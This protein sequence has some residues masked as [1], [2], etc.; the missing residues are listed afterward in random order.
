[1]K[2]LF[3]LIVAICNMQCLCADVVYQQN[4]DHFNNTQVVL[5]QPNFL[6]LGNFSGRAYERT[7]VIFS[8]M[9]VKHGETLIAQAKENLLKGAAERGVEL[10]GSI[11]MVNTMVEVAQSGKYDAVTVT[12]DLIEFFDEKN[13]PKNKSYKMKFFDND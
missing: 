1:M 3:F 4:V 7:G 9:K 12:A 2:K 13:S 10:N 8:N 6:Y 11:I 5:S